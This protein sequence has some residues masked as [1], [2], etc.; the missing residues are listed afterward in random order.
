MGVIDITAVPRHTWENPCQQPPSQPQA[1]GL[2]VRVAFTLGNLTASND[3]NRNT[4]GCKNNNTIK[5]CDVA[6]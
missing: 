6:V 2:L 3:R 1:S 4:T 5:T